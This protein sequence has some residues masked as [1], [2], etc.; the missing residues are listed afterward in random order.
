MEKGRGIYT[1]RA[2]VAKPLI[3]SLVICSGGSTWA[4][5]FWGG[6]IMGRKKNIC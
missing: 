2:P 6:G 4:R 3:A 5:T 1:R